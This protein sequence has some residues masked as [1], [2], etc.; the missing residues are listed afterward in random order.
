[1]LGARL[2]RGEEKDCVLGAG[3]GKEV[4]LGQEREGNPG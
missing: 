4:K 1:M 2:E 3:R